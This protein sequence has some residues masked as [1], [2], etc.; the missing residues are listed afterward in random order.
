VSYTY[1]DSGIRT[2]KIVNDVATDYYLNG[3]QIVTQLTDGARL[4]FFYDENGSLFGFNYNGANYYYIR[5]GQNDIIGIL[6]AS[7]NQVVTYTY[8]TW[9]KLLGITDTSTNNVGTLNPF[10]YRGYYYD[11]ETGLYYLQSRYYDPNTGRY[12]NADSDVGASTD[13]L[14]ANVFAYCNNN[15]VMR[16]DPSGQWSLFNSFCV[17]LAVTVLIICILQPELIPAAAAAL[18]EYGGAIAAT[19]G[20][21]GVVAEEALQEA[22]PEVEE[23]I[24]EVQKAIPEAQKVGSEVASKVAA[25]SNEISNEVNTLKNAGSALKPD[26]YHAFPKIVDNYADLA[27]KY[28]LGNASL[29]QLDGAY[30]GMSGRFEWIVQAGEVTHRLFIG[31][32]GINGIPIMP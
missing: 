25:A 22:A 27:T 29:Y 15:P 14:A 28:D 26:L 9:G 16:S 11:T 13:I 17:C 5:N 20:L 21:G 24:P 6:D 23:S 19:L 8:D 1:D 18:A 30:Q 12:L 2:Q 3:N 4:D 32:G 31:G 7:G 10:R